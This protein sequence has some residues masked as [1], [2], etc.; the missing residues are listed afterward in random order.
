MVSR[1]AGS[2]WNLLIAAIVCWCFSGETV[3]TPDCIE[4][5]KARI[6]FMIEGCKVR[7]VA[8]FQKILSSFLFFLFFFFSIVIVFPS[9]LGDFPW[10]LQ[11]RFYPD[12]MNPSI[13]HHNIILFFS[14]LLKRR[15]NTGPARDG[16]M[17]VHTAMWIPAR[18]KSCH[19]FVK[20]ACHVCQIS[21]VLN[22]R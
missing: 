22:L 5:S 16:R 15:S 9:D 3:W 11:K 19:K 18:F 4:S 6:L 17:S 14:V 20:I 10:F 2:S 8:F 1:S 21:R 12:D 7:V 13:K